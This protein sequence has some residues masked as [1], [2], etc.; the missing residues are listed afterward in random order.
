MVAG[1]SRSDFS[2]GTSDADET[3][4]RLALCR[5]AMST[6]SMSGLKEVKRT[7]RIRDLRQLFRREHPPLGLEARK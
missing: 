2:L 4:V 6:L 1:G 7:P 3:D 5:H